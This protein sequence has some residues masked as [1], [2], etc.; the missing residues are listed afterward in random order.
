MHG[1]V[2]ELMFSVQQTDVVV[3]V[4]HS[5]A[6][7]LVYSYITFTQEYTSKSRYRNNDTIE[8]KV[9]SLPEMFFFK[10]NTEGVKTRQS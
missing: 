5:I 10:F 7:S 9:Y 2:E 1:C 3:F 8:V 6:G 4:S